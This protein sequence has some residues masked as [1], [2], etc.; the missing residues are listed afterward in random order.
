MAVPEVWTNTRTFDVTAVVMKC[1]ILCQCL[2][3]VNILA[4]EIGG[5][6]QVPK[7]TKKKCLL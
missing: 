3:N 5:A 4:S 6:S 7:I 2:V 1:A